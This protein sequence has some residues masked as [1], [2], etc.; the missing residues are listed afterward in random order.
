MSP[1]S[2]LQQAQL[3]V[4]VIVRSIAGFVRAFFEIED[5]ED[6]Y[7]NCLKSKASKL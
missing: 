2:R 4:H 7:F 3:H 1:L 6:I 5:S